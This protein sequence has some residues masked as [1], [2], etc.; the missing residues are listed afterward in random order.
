[1]NVRF[2]DAKP[3]YETE[4]VRSMMWGALPYPNDEMLDRI[5][6]RYHDDE[7]MRLYGAIDDDDNLQGLIGLR[8][9]DDR[10]GTLLHLHV[11]DGAQRQGVGSALVRKAISH[12]KLQ[13]LSGRASVDLLPFFDSLGFSNWVIGEKPPGTNWYGVRWGDEPASVT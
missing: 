4:P 7:G 10:G 2:F 6:Q 13:R 1:M 8:I 11:H 9:D 5:L 12:M 3:H